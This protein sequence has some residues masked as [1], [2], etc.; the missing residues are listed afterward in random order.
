MGVTRT[1]VVAAVWLV[2][3][4]R[5]VVY[6]RTEPLA[7]VCVMREFTKAVALL[8]EPRPFALGA[9]SCSGELLDSADSAAVVVIGVPLTVVVIRAG[10][11]VTTGPPG[12]G[13]EPVWDGRKT[14]VVPLAMTENCC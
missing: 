3:T 8:P 6:V 14:E 4:G 2:A 12:L 7:A 9:P 11:P 10:T 13:R 5:K 1:L